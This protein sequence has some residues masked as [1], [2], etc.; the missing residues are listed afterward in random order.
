LEV[1][2]WR[3]RA[4]GETGGRIISVAALM[5]AVLMILPPP[6][7]GRKPPLTT[8]YVTSTRTA[9]SSSADE[10]AR[11]LADAARE[12]RE[13]VARKKGLQIVEDPAVADVQ[14][15]VTNRE[16]RDA[17]EGG[18]G[19]IKLTPLGEMIIRFHAKFAPRENGA[20][21]KGAPR[22]DEVDL[23][24]I[25]PGYWSRAAKDGAE[26][27]RKWIANRSGPLQP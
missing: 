24:G 16:A 17:G 4:R 13:A 8:V 9:G 10:E 12:L 26:R 22:T 19:G 18:F 23:K 5:M 1:G 3:L 14:V 6:A 2:G 27:L 11:G 15:E 21:G 25:G 7:S 20:P